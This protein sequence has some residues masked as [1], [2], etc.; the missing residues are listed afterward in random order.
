MQSKKFIEINFI[1]LKVKL[2]IYYTSFGFV[3]NVVLIGNITKLVTLNI[4][5]HILIHLIIIKY[6]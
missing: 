3:I 2:L 6:H 5:I 4:K 1:F